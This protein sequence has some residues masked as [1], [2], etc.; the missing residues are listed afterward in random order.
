MQLSNIAKYFIVTAAC[1]LLLQACGSTKPAD[2]SIIPPEDAARTEPP[3][4]NA[5]PENYQA[6][7]WQISPAGTEK[8]LIARKGDKW[9]V[10]NAYSDPKQTVTLHSDKDYV[11]SI[12]TKTYAE[13]TTGHGYDDRASTVEGV[14]D[15][16]WN[17]RDN[18][19]YEKIGTENG[20][21]K[22][23]VTG[24]PGK[25]VESIITID[26]ALGLPMMKEVYTSENGRALARTTKIADYK[27]TVDDN[28]FSIPKDFKK[29]PLEEMRKVLVAPNQ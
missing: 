9:R 10:D 20:K 21:T 15:G 1:V 27:T 22:Y 13:Y 26:D 18:A 4:Q 25:P 23:R 29:V 2:Q 8:F 11:L 24:A 28:A 14:T 16:L 17:R 7:V 6:E 12:A 3:F 5:E 19:V